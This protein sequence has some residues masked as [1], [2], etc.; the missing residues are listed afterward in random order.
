MR[1]RA[2]SGTLKVTSVVTSQS[3]PLEPAPAPRIVDEVGRSRAPAHAEERG[4]LRP[5]PAGLLSVDLADY[6]DGWPHR[7]RA[8]HARD[9]DGLPASPL[10]TTA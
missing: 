1:S 2:A 9:G 4:M 7:P 8:N 5:F 3:S 6:P 10:D